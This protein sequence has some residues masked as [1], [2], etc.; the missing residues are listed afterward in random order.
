[1]IKHLKELIK[2]LELRKPISWL[3]TTLKKLRKLE[4]G[5][6]TIGRVYKKQLKRICQ[7][8]LGRFGNKNWKINTFWKS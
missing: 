3:K 1:M 2:N 6:T 8:Q 5:D 4:R 7:E